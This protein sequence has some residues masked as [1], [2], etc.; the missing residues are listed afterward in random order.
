M[1]QRKQFIIAA[2]AEN[3]NISQLCREFGI[4]R[5]TGHKWIN[6]SEMGLPLCDQSRRPYRQPSKTAEDVEQKII[7]MRLAHPAWGG[8]TIRAALEAA[9]VE[10]L[11]S[12]KTCCNIIKR[13]GLSCP[14]IIAIRDNLLYNVYTI[15]TKK[16]NTVQLNLLIFFVLIIGILGIAIAAIKILVR[17]AEKHPNGNIEV[18]FKV[19]GC[20]FGAKASVSNDTQQVEL[21]SATSASTNLRITQPS[22][23]HSQK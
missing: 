6:R 22:T 3:A 23:K 17:F 12:D 19:L 15:Y 1:E 5:K 18:S 13:N 10:G 7:Q 4:S 2:S 8:K 9:G 14:E 20:S 16:V 11:P 21:P